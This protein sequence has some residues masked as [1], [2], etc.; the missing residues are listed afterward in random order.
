MYKRSLYIS[1][2]LLLLF[3]TGCTQRPTPYFAPPSVVENVYNHIVSIAV[4]YY[5][6]P[7]EWERRAYLNESVARIDVETGETYQGKPIKCIAYIGSGVIVRNNL[8]LTVR[9]LFNHTENTYAR[10]IWVFHQNE[11]H[12]IEADLIAMTANQS[13]DDKYNDYACIQLT[14]DL[15]LPGIVVAKRDVKLGEKVMF[16]CSVG[17]TAYFLRFGYAGKFKWF[18]RRDTDGR[19]HLSKMRDYYFTTAHP[20]GPGDSGSGVF[21]IRGELVGIIYIGVNIYEE[22]YSFTNPIKCLHDFLKQFKL[23]YLIYSLES[24]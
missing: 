4:Y 5:M 17:G 20:S 1:L 19:L 6:S 7:E 18:F 2:V 8:I 9:H 21:N 23:D 11:D 15:G 16:G 13:E 14:E 12:P 3:A 24:E 22:M 10:K